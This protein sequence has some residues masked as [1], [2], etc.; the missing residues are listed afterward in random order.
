MFHSLSCLE[1][2]MEHQ[3]K[4]QVVSC[5]TDVGIP[6]GLFLFTR[7]HHSYWIRLISHRL[8][9][10]IFAYQRESKVSLVSILGLDIPEQ[11]IEVAYDLIDGLRKPVYTQDM[12]DQQVKNLLFLLSSLIE[13]SQ[14]PKANAEL[15]EAFKVDKLFRKTSFIGRRVMLD[16]KTSKDRLEAILKFF[17]LALQLVKTLDP[18][19]EDSQLMKDSCGPILELV[20]RTSTDEQY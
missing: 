5:M 2:L 13:Q 8:L 6:R 16:I 14:G 11:L 4:A 19:E 17:K 15:K 3:G 18:T 1:A 10:H 20:Y 12:Q 9:G 7:S